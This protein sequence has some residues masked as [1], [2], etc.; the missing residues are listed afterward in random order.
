MKK[1]R[2]IITLCLCSLFL[3]GNVQKRVIDDVNIATGFGMDKSNGQLHGSIM[4]PVFKA[5]KSIENFTFTANGKIPRDLVSEMQKKASQPI[6][7]GSLDIA[8]FGKDLARE[9]IIQVLDVF[10]RDP[11]IGARLN[12]AVVDGKVDDIFK[13]N[14]GDRGNHEYLRQLLEQNM[15]IHNLPKSN[16]HFFLADF[17]EEGK[18]AYLPLLKKTQQDLVN[19]A[20]I[21]LFKDEKLVDVLHENKLFYF[22]LLVDKHT[23]GSVMVKEVHGDASVKSIK[24][25]HNLKIIKR[26]PYKFGFHIKIKGYLTEHQDGILKENEIKDIEKQLEKQIVKECTMM[27]EDFQKKEIDPIGFGHFAQ[28]RTRNFDFNKWQENYKSAQFKITA[29]VNIVQIGVVK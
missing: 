7:G 21:A 3:A 27:V 14:Y 25:T 9:G 12:L 26:N 10:L 5:D 28:T 18:D 6:V 22:K 17:Y 2:F 20:G 11:T 8:L 23:E 24:S 1:F 4:I 29:D 19:I 16:L 15:K 13:G